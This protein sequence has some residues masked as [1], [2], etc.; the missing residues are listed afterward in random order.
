MGG[1]GSGPR[2]RSHWPSDRGW[3]DWYQKAAWRKIARAQL[4]A[5]PICERCLPKIV[6]AT[7]CDH[8]VDHHGDP[9]KFWNPPAGFASLC[10]SCHSRDKQL[11]SRHGYVPGADSNGEPTDPRHP[12]FK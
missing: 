12:W 7:I 5:Q 2:R 11:E 3:R 9:Q 4:R 1:P 8:R 6:P 10:A